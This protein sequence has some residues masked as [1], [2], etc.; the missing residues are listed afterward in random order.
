MKRTPLERTV[1]LRRK[2]DLARKKKIAP[3][4]RK[5]LAKLRAKQFGEDG[6]REFVL[7]HNC[8][9][10]GALHHP[11]MTGLYQVDPCHVGKTRGAGGGP[12]M[13]APLRRD[14]HRAFDSSMTDERFEARYGMSR[15]AIR[16][17]AVWL[18]NEFQSSREAA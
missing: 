12:E 2:T 11:R 10:T 14:V 18:E 1:G 9:V 3:V 7:S 5:R 6:K 15:D 4:N 13:M 16:Q 8:P 17:F